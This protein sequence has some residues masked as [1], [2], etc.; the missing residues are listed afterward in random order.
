[1]NKFLSLLLFFFLAVH[2]VSVVSGL[3]PCECITKRQLLEQ[4][5]LIETRNASELCN[6]LPPSII[7]A[8]PKRAINFTT[9]PYGIITYGNTVFVAE[10]DAGKVHKFDHEGNL[11]KIFNLPFGLATFMEIRDDKLYVTNHR[12]AIYVKSACNDDDN[13][14]VFVNPGFTPIAIRFTPNGSHFLV[15][16]YL[17]G[18]VH[19][20]NTQSKD[21]V[22][23]ITVTGGGLVTD[24]REIHFDTNGNM[25]INTLTPQIY[26]YDEN[27]NFLQTVTYPGASNI[28][29]WIFQCDGSKILADI[30]GK[31]IFVDKDDNVVQIHTEGYSSLRHVGITENGALF[32]SDAGMKKV[33]IY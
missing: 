32:I 4:L 9:R 16:E 1:M 15:G 8:T 30:G 24:E 29:G 12:A 18:K 5:Q 14:V 3:C 26:T 33:F 20:F 25:I 22:Q 11:L 7:T 2:H 6:P 13:F 21:I 10:F 19:V 31:V 23:I 17:R 27:F 28:D